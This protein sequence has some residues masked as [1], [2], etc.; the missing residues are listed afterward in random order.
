MADVVVENSMDSDHAEHSEVT[1]SYVFNCTELES[2]ETVDVEMFSAWPGI[3][4][5]DVQL[6]GPK[7]QNAMELDPD[8]RQID[9]TSV[10]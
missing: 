3:D 10:L 5:I 6:A 8:D 4:D 2:L 1:V 9:M 7:R